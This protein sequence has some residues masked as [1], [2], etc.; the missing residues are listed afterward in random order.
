[1]FSAAAASRRC[2]SS[3]KEALG[4]FAGAIAD[5]AKA[6]EL[7]PGGARVVDLAYSMGLG[8]Q[9]AEALALVDRALESAGDDRPRLLNAR[10]DL[11]SRLGRGDE[12]LATLAELAAERPGDAAILNQRCWLSGIWEIGLDTIAE[13][14]DAAV[15][16]ANYSPAVLDS[17]ALANLRLGKLDAALSDA[18]AGLARNPGQEETLLLRGLVREKLGDEGGAVD[19]AEAF[20]RRPGL[21]AEYAQYGL[22]SAK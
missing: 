18:E 9:A 14:C 16:A 3:A 20:R 5:N 11:L 19:L 17:R 6:A 2:G 8:G 1:M 13:H 15:I 10:A 12:A 4:D 22:L 21:R 7:E